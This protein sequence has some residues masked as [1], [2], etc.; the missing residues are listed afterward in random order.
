MEDGKELGEVVKVDKRVGRKPKKEKRHREPTV[1]WDP[2][3]LRSCFYH[4]DW[5]SASW[6][7]GRFL[8]AR[9][10]R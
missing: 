10:L 1:R 6:T 9:L 7:G 4:T 5:S 8:L 3:A 2:R